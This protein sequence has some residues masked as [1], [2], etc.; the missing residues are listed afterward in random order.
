[1]EC[2]LYMSMGQK[3]GFMYHPG[4]GQ[5]GLF[6]LNGIEVSHFGQDQELP[7]GVVKRARTARK[8]EQG[9]KTLRGRQG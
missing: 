9:A 8:S 7:S 2:Q 4:E 6:L 5:E 1:M 3:T